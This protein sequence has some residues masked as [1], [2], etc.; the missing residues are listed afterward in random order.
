MPVNYHMLNDFRVDHE[1]ALDDLLTQMLAVLIRGGLVTVEPDRPGRHP[2]PRRLPGP[3]A[4]SRRETIER[5]SAS[6]PGSTWRSSSGQAARAEDATERRRP[7]EAA[8]RGAGRPAGAG[9]GGVGRRSKQ[10]KAQ[11]KDK[12]TKENPPRASTTDP[13]ARFMRMPDGGTRPAYNV[14]LAVDTESRA[15]VGVDVTNAGSDAGLDAP[16]RDQVEGRAD[17]AVDGALIDGGYVSWSRS[18]GR[19]R[20]RWTLYMPVPEPRKPGVDPH[21][22]K[23]SDSEAVAEWRRRMATEEAKAIYKERG[24]TIETINGETKTYRGMVPV[25][26]RGLKKVRVRAC[27]RRWR[28]TSFTSARRLWVAK[29]AAVAR[30]E[31]RDDQGPR[32][33]ARR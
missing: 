14:Q 22:P 26:V 17:E 32:R 18:S 31:D 9:A 11:Q 23:Q 10:A 1:A 6:R 19:P 8:A 16:M 20:R 2:R 15:I 28:T 13:E 21:E 25:L 7:A 29:W 24:S 4:S 3:T 27:G 30:E 5:A 12:P 33:L